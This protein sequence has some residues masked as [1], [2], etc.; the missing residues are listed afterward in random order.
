MGNLIVSTSTFLFREAC[1]CVRRVRKGFDKLR[2]NPPKGE[3]F[4]DT[5]Q[6]MLSLGVYLKKVSRHSYRLIKKC[7]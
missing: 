2:T 1:S 6:Q 3:F 5:S 7:K 4:K